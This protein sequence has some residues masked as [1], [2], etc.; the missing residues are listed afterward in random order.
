MKIL[1]IVQSFGGGGAA[2]GVLQIVNGVS[3]NN[4]EHVICSLNSH[5]HYQSELKNKEKC[6]VFKDFLKTGFNPI[7]QAT[8]SGSNPSS[9]CLIGEGMVFPSFASIIFM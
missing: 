6:L 9:I 4:I 8:F 5:T 7:L 1:H 3:E 2:R